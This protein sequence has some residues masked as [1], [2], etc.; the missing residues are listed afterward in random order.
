MAYNKFKTPFGDLYYLVG[1]KIIHEYKDED[2]AK[3][4]FRQLKDQFNEYKKH[5][6][7]LDEAIEDASNRKLVELKDSKVE[8]DKDAYEQM[9]KDFKEDKH[10]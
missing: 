6:A 5:K 4:I 3:E 10:E 1:K 9:K 2:E 8:M 7:E